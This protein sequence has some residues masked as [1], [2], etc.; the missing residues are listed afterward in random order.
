MYVIWP[1]KHYTG[2]QAPDGYHV[3]EC[4]TATNIIFLSSTSDIEHMSSKDNVVADYLSRTTPSN[5]SMEIDYTVMASAQVASNQIQAYRTA[6]T[7]LQL[8]EIHVCPAG[9][10]KII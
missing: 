10:F 6:I 7:N 4:T 5:V 9:T 2:I 3:S 8:A 1:E